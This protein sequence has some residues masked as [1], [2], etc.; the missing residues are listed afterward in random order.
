MHTNNP[1]GLR[2]WTLQGSK[3]V[4]RITTSWAATQVPLAD[5]LALGPGVWDGL[6]ARSGGGSPFLTWAWHRAWAA[7]AP[8]EDVRSCHAVVLRAPTGD[9]DGLFP[10][11]VERTSFWGI[12]VTG[13]GWAFGD[14][15]APVHLELLAAREADLDSL[16]GNLEALPWTVLRLGNVADAAVNV[17]RLCAACEGRG[18]VTRR[19]AAGRCLYLDLPT[20]WDAY[21][22]GLSA[23]A[24]HGLRH[25]ERKLGREHEVVLTDYGAH[26]VEEGLRHLRRLHTLR[27]G[28]GGAFRD[29]AWERLHREFAAA[30]AER[31]QLWLLTLDLDGEPAAAWYG[32]ALGDT[33]YHY[34]SGRDPRWERERVG[35]VLMSMIIRRAIERGYRRLDFLRGEE[36]YKAEWTSTARPYHEVL[37][38]RPG[39]RG[40][41]LRTVDWV[42]RTAQGALRTLVRRS[43]VLRSAMRASST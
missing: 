22:S 12:P 14:L 11:R 36:P 18:W 42:A 9:V 13:V 1:R 16:V 29:P 4:I 20:S 38:F 25:K 39:W 5:A 23:H 41:A 35:T 26:R 28:G 43:R 31:G 21:L 15:G 24:R 3:Y 40:A 17:V 32:F 10:F 30:L 6:L 34:Q 33:V 7:A 8:P 27:W 37:V 19:R 2:R